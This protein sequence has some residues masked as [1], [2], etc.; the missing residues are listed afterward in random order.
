MQKLK[1]PIKYDGKMLNKFVL[2]SFPKLPQ[3]Q[4]YK[5]LRKKD[6]RINDV[7]VNDNAILHEG[8]IVTIYI[9]D[10]ILEGNNTIQIDKVFEDDN[11]LVINKPSQIEVVSYNNEESLTSILKKEYSYIEPCHR[12]DR[13]TKGLVLFAKNEDSLHILLEAFKTHEIEKHYKA[14]VYGKPIKDHDILDAYLFKDSKK[15]QVYISSDAKEGYLPIETEYSVI[16]INN[17]GTSL[18]DVV[19]HTGRTHQ[20]RAHLAYMGIPIIG[21][22]KYGKNEINKK[23]GKTTQ[24]LTA[25]MLKFCFK[26]DKGMLDYLNNLE[27]KL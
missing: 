14:L 24:Q 4:F 1:V 10:N 22:G 15:S 26:N 17:D 7:K 9:V 25:Y 20:I 18:L 8:D 3:N 6:I 11:I 12:L 27:I 21:D 13:N 2:D 5:A 23:F 16:S 19:L